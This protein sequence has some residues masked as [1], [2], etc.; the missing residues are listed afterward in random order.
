MKDLTVFILTHNRPQLVQT[1]IESVLKQ[2]PFDFKF[3]VSDNSDNDETENILKGKSY[4]NEINYYHTN[5][6]GAD[7]WHDIFSRVETKYFMVFHD[8]DE[9][10]PNMI[11][12]LYEKITSERLYAVGCN[13]KVYINGKYSHN[14]IKHNKD[15]TI[16]DFNSFSEAWYRSSNAPFPSY[17]YNKECMDVFP[18]DFPAGKFS[19]SVFLG[20]IVK[21]MGSIAFLTRPEFIYNIHSGQDSAIYDYLSDYFLYRYYMNNCEGKP[22]FLKE[23]K[24]RILYRLMK[25]EFKNNMT[26]SNIKAKLLFKYSKIIYLRFML[27]RLSKAYKRYI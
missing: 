24:C 16:T 4:F 25:N 8:D 17:I 21:K 11:N 22:R 6:N 5:V 3:V 19:D 23:Y 26:V 13:A 14:Y 12:L 7:R 9:M 1:A 20:N 27:F 18:F 2:K 10:L 15:I